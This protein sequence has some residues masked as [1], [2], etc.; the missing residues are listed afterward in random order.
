MMHRMVAMVA[1]G[2]LVLAGEARATPRTPRTPQKDS[3]PRP[4]EVQRDGKL[5]VVR[6]LSGGEPQ[7]TIEDGSRF[8]LTGPLRDELLRLEGHK[9]RIWAV[10]GAKKLLMDTLDVSRFEILDAGG[11]RRPL[12]GVLRKSAG[13]V[14]NLER[15]KAASLE[16]EASRALHAEL[17]KRVG[18]RIWVVGELEGT[19]VKAFKFGWLSCRTPKSIKPDKENKK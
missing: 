7:L 14:L 2:A 17:E 3:K 13:N 16:I 11:G 18:C 10:P 15:P 19:T 4:S 8:L 1:L 6:G 5:L 12:V 9:L